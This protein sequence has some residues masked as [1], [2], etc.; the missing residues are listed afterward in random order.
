[1]G[2][3]V[4]ELA[5]RLFEE[6]RKR[7]PYLIQSLLSQAQE[8]ERS[9]P[10]RY[11]DADIVMVSEKAMNVSFNHV[12]ELYR[13]ALEASGVKVHVMDARDA[14]SHINKPTL[15]YPVFSVLVNRR[16]IPHTP[17][18]VGME[19]VETD[20]L[21]DVIVFTLKQMD[22]I[23]TF[24]EYARK[25]L[26]LHGIKS[27]VVPHPYHPLFI[28]SPRYPKHQKLQE[29]LRLKMDHGYILA[30]LHL[31]HSGFRKGV[32]NVLLPLRRLALRYPNFM[33]VIKRVDIIDHL[34][35]S[36]KVMVRN[37]EIEEFLDPDDYV[38][39]YDI[40]DIV[41]MP[42]R[43]EGFGMVALEALVRGKITV[44]PDH[45]MYHYRDYCVKVKTSGES[46][47]DEE[48]LIHVGRGV[49]IDRDDFYE[50]M[51]DIMEHLDSY[52]ERFRKQAREVRLKY[53]IA[54]IGQQLVSLLKS[55]GVI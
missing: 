48:N 47:Y 21:S 28:R 24:N 4:L 49:D 27:H 33:L 19:V 38:D 12:S 25:I 17:V 22:H 3:D 18:K 37:F 11:D 15:F 36:L 41:I 5:R 9:R 44:I 14:P 16:G 54:N 8:G 1:M 30:L 13:L 42:S 55:W 34:L 45:E 7:D 2:E 32:D 46:R 40:V 29:L 53:S 20:K 6:L 35:G 10:V 31:W 51:V 50:K 39:L 43:G 52:V 23:I 26:E